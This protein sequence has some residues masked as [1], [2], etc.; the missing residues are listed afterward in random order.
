LRTIWYEPSGGTTFIQ[1]FFR[2]DVRVAQTFRSQIAML[3]ER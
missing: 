1:H 3:D 2:T